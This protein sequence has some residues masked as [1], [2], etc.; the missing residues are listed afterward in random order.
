MGIGGEKQMNQNERLF[1]RKYP[2]KR[3]KMRTFIKQELKRLK[4][5]GFPDYDVSNVA[6]MFTKHIINI[7]EEK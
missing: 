4:H 7:L 3:L 5:L 1:D 6:S 2:G